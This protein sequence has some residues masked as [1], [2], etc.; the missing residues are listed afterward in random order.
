VPVAPS[1]PKARDLADSAIARARACEA[2]NDLESACLA[3][4]LPASSP[5]LSDAESAA[6]VAR[7]RERLTLLRDQARARRR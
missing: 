6:L 3:L 1:G 7:E 2:Q 4:D 5:I